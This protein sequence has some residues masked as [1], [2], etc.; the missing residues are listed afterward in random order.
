M[1]SLD[2]VK[3]YFELGWQC[4]ICGMHWHTENATAEVSCPHCEESFYAIL[5]GFAHL[6][7]PFRIE[8]S[9]GTPDQSPI[10][11]P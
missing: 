8:A 3:V 6:A 11:N 10:P 7:A 1:V 2:S 4:P 9:T 5:G